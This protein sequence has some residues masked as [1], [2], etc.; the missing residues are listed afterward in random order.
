MVHLE[1]YLLSLY[2]KAFEVKVQEQTC[3]SKVLNKQDVSPHP[4]AQLHHHHIEV[5]KPATRYLSHQLETFKAATRKS[6]AKSGSLLYK[7]VKASADHDSF[8]G[9][10]VECKE[11]GKRR[12]NISHSQP[13]TLSRKVVIA[14]F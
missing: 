11:P 13:I 5:P 8:N 7:Y 14:E 2:R 4:D 9:S 10:K 3:S 1:Q 12:L 6:H